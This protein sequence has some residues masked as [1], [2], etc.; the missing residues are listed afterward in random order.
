M[1]KIKLF[2]YGASGHG[3]VV[4]DIAEL[5]GYSV[6]G[7]IDDN[8]QNAI[9][10]D[11]FLQENPDAFVALGIGNNDSRALVYRRLKENGTKVATLIHPNAIVAKTAR[12]GEG[13]VVMAGSV[14]NPDALIERGCI[15]NTLSVIEHDNVIDQFCHVSPGVNLAGSVTVAPFSH[16]GIGSCVIQGVHIGSGSIIGAGSTVLHDIPDNSTAVGSPAKVI[17][18]G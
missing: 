17:K 8:A 1:G 2:V 14:I 12:I 3:K 4:A 10:Y 9:S 16:I 13:S 7:Y 6:E 18:H 5:C 15:I 11:L